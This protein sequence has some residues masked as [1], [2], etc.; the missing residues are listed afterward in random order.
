MAVTGALSGNAASLHG[1]K[2]GS[3][4]VTRKLKC[5]SLLV[6]SM[7]NANLAVNGSIVGRGTIPIRG[8][9]VW[10]GS[11]ASIPNGWA[12]CDGG[13]YNNLQTPDLRDRFIVGA[14]SGSNYKVGEKNGEAM[15]T[16]S[17]QEMP[18]HAHG[19]TFKYAAKALAKN[20]NEH[21]YSI[22]DNPSYKEK[23]A[24]TDASG[25]GWAHE[26]RPP[27]YALCYIMRVK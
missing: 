1:T 11:Q 8:I 7:T 4:A 24:S 18:S 17:A 9:V 13:K 2:A 6:N 25:G 10:S 22:S 23:S 26:N 5:G 27:Y 3:L 12:L 16:L 20:G 15:H 19:Y 14:G 21:F